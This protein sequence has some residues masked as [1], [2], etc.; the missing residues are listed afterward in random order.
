MER[1]VPTTRSPLGAEEK[2][3]SIVD[4]RVRT[5]KGPASVMVVTPKNRM[6]VDHARLDRLS[7]PAG[8]SP[9][10]M[11]LIEQARL[12]GEGARVVLFRAVNEYGER[13]W[14]FDPS[15]TDSDL[16]QGGT[17]MTRALLPFH[18]GLLESGVVLMVHTDWGFR[19]SYAFRHGVRV[20]A[21]Q[22][23]LSR[24]DDN[25]LDRWILGKMLMHVALKL[26][27]VVRTLLPAH[28]GLLQ[29]RV[30]RVAEML[31]ARR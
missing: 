9:V 6:V 16:E 1:R 15:F 12:R 24:S 27:H 30:D 20:L 4:A 13:V 22:L 21:E 14:E 8:L 18:R 10:E 17:I 26:D 7:K 25:E 3:F 28:M 29:Q 2:P 5:N 31:R 11:W 23:S 19:E